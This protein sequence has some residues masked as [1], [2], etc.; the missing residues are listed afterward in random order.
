MDRFALQ[1]SLGYVEAEEEV[2]IPSDQERSHPIEN[3]SPRVTVEDALYL[4]NQVRGIHISDELKRYIVEMVRSTR[5]F[6][7]VSLGASPRASLSLM[8]TAKALALFDG[9]SFVTPDQI[10]EVA[11]P[12]IA[13]R[14]VMDPQA[15]FSGHTARAVV[16]EILTTLPVP[17]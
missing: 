2:S 13:H 5:S 14:I 17:A 4:K 15:R 16:E 1:F 6:Q 9:L 8:R 11:V 10:Q 3:A 7:G 12:V